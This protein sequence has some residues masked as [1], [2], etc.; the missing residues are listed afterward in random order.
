MNIMLSVYKQRN[1]QGDKI[2]DTF[3]I[4]YQEVID[5]IYTEIF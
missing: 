5:N 4:I 3:W 1:F 2:Y